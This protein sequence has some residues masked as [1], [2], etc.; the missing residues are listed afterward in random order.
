MNACYQRTKKYHTMK[1]AKK[2]ELLVGLTIDRFKGIQPS[3]LIKIINKLGLEFAELTRSVFDDLE[4]VKKT[5]GNMETGLHLPNL[6]D[7]GFDFSNKSRE[8][9]IKNLIKLINENHQELNINYCLSHPPE[10]KTA[11][12]KWEESTNY[13]LEN[14]KQIDAPE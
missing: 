13:L 8:S 9:D 11:K 10:G 12:E 1:I 7:S 3:T 6:H 5:L 2:N 4:N 14:L